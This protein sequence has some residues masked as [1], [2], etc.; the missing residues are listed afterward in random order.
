M[1]YCTRRLSRMSM[2]NDVLELAAVEAVEAEAAA[3]PRR[4]SV[5]RS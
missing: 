2:R 3:R 1:P 4:D 5:R